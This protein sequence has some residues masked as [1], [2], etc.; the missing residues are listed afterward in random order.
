MRNPRQP[1]H[2][3]P[4][5]PFSG[6]NV[7]SPC[8]PNSV[9]AL[10]PDPNLLRSSIVRT[11]WIARHGSRID[12]VDPDWHAAA[13]HP[14]DPPLCPEGGEQARQLGERLQKE[15]IAHIFAS[16]FLRTV[17]TAHAVASTLDLP[18][19]LEPGFSEWLN[20]DWFPRD[21]RRVPLA[22]LRRRFPRIDP[23]YTPRGEASYPETGDRAEKRSGDTLVR[24]SAEFE[25]NLLVV[26]H[27]V[28]VFGATAGLLDVPPGEPRSN[29]LPPI[30]Y[31][32]LVKLT[33]NRNG[34]SLELACDT[35]HLT[36]TGGGD[37]FH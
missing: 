6:T 33:Q 37:R 20:P 4:D 29:L 2:R 9:A 11:I 12:F 24:L 36:V 14:Y 3:T 32:S 16:P 35:S 27:G 34:W 7:C 26:G 10:W 1:F 31:C 28:S 25:G 30:T 23:S 5:L 13:T 22:D 21:P 8:S 18:V 17:E 19:K 15:S